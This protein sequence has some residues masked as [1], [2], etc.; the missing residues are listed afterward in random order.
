MRLLRCHIDNFGKF[1]DY[2]VDFIRNPFIFNE[3]N[4]WGKSTLAT[5]IKVM[6][7]GFANEKK[8]GDALERERTR[9]K[10]WQGGSYGGEIEFET[11]GKR[12][13]LN[14]TFG[15]KESEDSFI[16]YDAVT[17]LKSDDFSD[18]VGEE[19]FRINQESFLKTVFI[20]QSSCQTSV[21]DSVNAKIGNLADCLDDM[22]KYEKVQQIIKDIRNSLN[23]SR[24]TG[25]RSLK[26]QKEEISGLRDEL[27]RMETVE[28]SA[29]EL[30][31]RLCDCRRERG[32]LAV[33]R[34]ET[35]EQWE[36]MTQRKALE[37][38]KVHYESIIRQYDA[39]KSMTENILAGMGGKAPERNIV[40]AM[41]DKRRQMIR[42]ES[43]ADAN[44][45]SFEEKEKLNRIG[46]RFTQ[47]TPTR[48]DMERGQTLA[49]EY[50][51]LRTESVEHGLSREEVQEYNTLKSR[52]GDVEDDVISMA[53]ES[54]RRWGIYTDKKNGLGTKKATLSSLRLLT[55]NIENNRE[56]QNYGSDGR[57][58]AAYAAV[59]LIMAVI[60]AMAGAALIA[61]SVFM[62]LQYMLPGC[63]LEVSGVALFVLALIF[64]ARNNKADSVNDSSH[65]DDSAMQ[66]NED[67]GAFILEREI[68][69]DEEQMAEA[70]SYVEG[71]LNRFGIEIDADVAEVRDMLYGI[72]NDMLRFGRLRARLCDYEQRGYEERLETLHKQACEI[73][74][75]YCDEDKLRESGLSELYSELLRDSDAFEVLRGRRRK[76]ESARESADE[77]GKELLRFLTEY[78]QGGAPDIDEGIQEII[79][80]LDDYENNIKD[81]DRLQRERTDFETENDI[82]KF[83]MRMPET[84]ESEEQIKQR[85]D[86]LDD[87]IALLMEQEHSYQA[88][89]DERQQD[90]DELQIQSERLEQLEAEYDRDYAYYTNLGITAE[91]LE[92]AKESLSAKYIGP[93]LESFRKYYEMLSGE[94]GENFRI[95][96]NIH[97]TRRDMGEQRE[98]KAFSAGSQDLMNIVLRVALVEAMY[99]DECPF[100]IFDDSFVNLDSARMDT[101]ARFLEYIS[102]RYQVIYFTC[103][104]SRAF[105][106][107]KGFDY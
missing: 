6:F 74:R 45:L 79:R 9:F 5:F 39:K 106:I 65:N 31:T 4:G 28:Q 72:K 96:A 81:L 38:S 41:T 89:L 42:Q 83:D 90:L 57:K 1:S 37:A 61:G 44:R 30:Q 67:D 92:K 3:Q 66:G 71:F 73:L 85:M 49:A 29:N 64:K 54:L 104:E 19:L 75:P 46:G 101:A 99:Q 32:E 34:R 103:H 59:L 94:S 95:D 40:D 35:Q 2:T 27:R 88:Q 102:Q 8:R 55:R 43:E 91:Y 16:L 52:L 10:P 17:N 24:K 70:K 62:E 7:Y 63:I 23:P 68:V 21:T 84:D 53:D 47:G 15:N 25:S 11:K 69:S 14:R 26:K 48:E 22:N 100:L 12:Y 50:E 97:V 51:R 86:S 56:K 13:I 76:Y 82:N 107:K 60:C 18:N 93:V 78:G 58:S 87:R 36:L 33:R 105:E 98:I 77:T 20:A 80:R